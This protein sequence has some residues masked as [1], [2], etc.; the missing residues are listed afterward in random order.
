MVLSTITL[1]PFEGHPK[2]PNIF[3]Q[4]SVA[5]IVYSI[6][7]FAGPVTGAHLNPAVTL[8]VFT[9]K[10]REK[11]DLMVI[12][13]YVVAEL[14]GCFVGTVANKLIYGEG[15]V[16]YAEFPDALELMKDCAEEFV[17]T[18]LLIMFIFI[19]TNEETTFVHS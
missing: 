13:T 2:D 15:I 18:F 7:C 17:G 11:G 5:L 4:I 6:I 8:A 19:I 3:H 10:K 16:L 12:L 14:S 9:S 1:Q